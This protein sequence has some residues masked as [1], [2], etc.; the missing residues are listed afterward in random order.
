MRADKIVKTDAVEATSAG[1]I[2]PAEEE[3]HRAGI[4]GKFHDF[5][6][7]GRTPAAAASCP[8][9][10]RPSSIPALDGRRSSSR[11]RK[12]PWST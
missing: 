8:V 12:T 3:G 1:G 4:H 5:K 2:S 10:S 7:K 9:L 11:S 6:G